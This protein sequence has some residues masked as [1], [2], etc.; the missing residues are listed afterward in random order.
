[1]KKHIAGKNFAE[2]RRKSALPENNAREI[3]S[4]EIF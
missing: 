1:M 4:T 2:Y 3:V